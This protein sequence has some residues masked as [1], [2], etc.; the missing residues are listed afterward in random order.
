VEF[1]L[2]LI[3]IYC[4]TWTSCLNCCICQYPFG[5]NDS[6]AYHESLCSLKCSSL[7]K[8]FCCYCG[9]TFPVYNFLQLVDHESRCS[10]NQ[11]V[12]SSSCHHVAKMKI[13][14]C[15]SLCQSAQSNNSSVVKDDKL[16]RAVLMKNCSQ[17]S[18]CG[19][20]NHQEAR[21][22]QKMMFKVPGKTAMSD[23]VVSKMDS[24]ALIKKGNSAYLIVPIVKHV[25]DNF[26]QNN[27]VPICDCVFFVRLLCSL[28]FAQ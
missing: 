10:L 1:I 3:L 20:D 12:Q 7:S 15:C 27:I 21:L 11:R 18:F 6:K 24:T 5:D 17:A 19:G 16:D 23:V 4:C 26:N 9:T 22:S 14:S 13:L 2:S 28:H 25:V 8:F